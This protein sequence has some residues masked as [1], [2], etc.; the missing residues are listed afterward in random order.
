ML[1]RRS[2]LFKSFCKIDIY[3]D[4]LLIGFG[5]AG[6]N[7]DKKM[8]LKLSKVILAQYI[9]VKNKRIFIFDNNTDLYKKIDLKKK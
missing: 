5:N 2:S 3:M 1:K 8:T 9:I 7:Y 6:I 4:C